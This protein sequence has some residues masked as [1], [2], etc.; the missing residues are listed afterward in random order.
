MSKRKQTLIDLPDII[1]SIQNAID[2]LEALHVHLSMGGKINLD[3]KQLCIEAERF[4][5]KWKAIARRYVE[6][7]IEK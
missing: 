3:D 6:R 4:V 7:Q 5:E 1:D 2:A